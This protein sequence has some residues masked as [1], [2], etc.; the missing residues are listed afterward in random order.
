MNKKGVVYPVDDELQTSFENSFPYAETSDQLSAINDCK[1]DMEQ[2]KIMDRLVCGDV[3]FGKTE[4]ALRIAFKTI[5]S[6]R[7]VAFLCPTTILSEQH[8]ST[9]KS[10]FA[11]FGVK[12][13]VLNRLKSPS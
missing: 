6:G 5:M 8:Y 4:V 12:V 1:K 11:D 2:G 3:G 9:A 13:E 7:Q 10:R